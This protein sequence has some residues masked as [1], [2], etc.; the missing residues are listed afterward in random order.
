M[1]CDEI[2]RGDLIESY[3]LGRL[4]AD[5]RDAVDAHL[6]ECDRCF[7]R[8][9]TLRAIRRELAA[10][11]AA[12]PVEA[13]RWPRWDWRWA[14]V[15]AFAMLV[16]VGALVWPRAVPPPSGRTAPS[17]ERAAA[18][19]GARPGR[20]P[21]FGA[22]LTE[23]GRFEPPA[24]EPGTLRGSPDAATV[25]FR[26]AMTH[27]AGGEYRAA[28]AG[29]R[30]AAA[31]DPDAAHAWFFLGICHAMSGALDESARALRE[32]IAAGETPY[33]EE[34][35]FHLALVLLQKGETAAARDELARTIGMGGP[36]ESR[37]RATLARLDE[38]SPGR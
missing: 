38:L 6:F 20:G 7:E 34:A 19:P 31:L 33:L 37:A 11:R 14:L 25:R 18:D 8:L 27:Y 29:L 13:A 36:L 5:A 26:D 12:Q 3:L 4:S 22:R 16:I 2:E 30:T 28:I 15:P 24:Y 32:T 9:E 1:T 23:L 10:T 17:T 21:E 35:H